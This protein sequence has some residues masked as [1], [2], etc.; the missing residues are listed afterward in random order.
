LKKIKL[1]TG[2]Y[3]QNYGRLILVKKVRKIDGFI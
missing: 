2:N 1:T 3:G